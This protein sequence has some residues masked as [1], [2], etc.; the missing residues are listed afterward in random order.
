MI[1]GLLKSQRK[2]F[3]HKSPPKICVHV[4]HLLPIKITS[5]LLKFSVRD[6]PK[7]LTTISMLPENQCSEI[8]ILHNDINVI[9]L[10]LLF[11]ILSWMTVESDCGLWYRCT[12]KI[13]EWLWTLVQMYTKICWKWLWALVQRCTKI[14]W[15][16]LWALVQ[17]YKKN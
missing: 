7:I 4:H 11:G 12:Q 10:H 9:L 14:F 3:Q 16:W 1:Q 13:T 2:Y 5:F 15:E 8:H 6:L 17:M